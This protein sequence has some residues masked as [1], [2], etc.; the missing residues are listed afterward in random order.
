MSFITYSEP[1]EHTI[2]KFPG[3]GRVDFKQEFDKNDGKFCDVLQK[4]LE[5]NPYFRGT[6][7][8]LLKHPVFDSVRQPE[9]EQPAGIKIDMPEDHPGAF[10]YSKVNDDPVILKQIINKLMSM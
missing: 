6:A 3:Y 9:L 7:G 1:A 8:S 5:F 2:E 4:L 10:D